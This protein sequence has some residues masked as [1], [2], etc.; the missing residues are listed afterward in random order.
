MNALTLPDRTAD[1]IKAEPAVGLSWVPLVALGLVWAQVVSRLQLEWSINPQYSYGWAVPFLCLY[2]AWRRRETLPAPSRPLWPG[3]GLVFALLAVLAFIPIRLVQEANPDWRLLSWAMSL[4]AVCITFAVVNLAGGL[5]WCRHFAFPILFFLVAVPWPTQFEQMVIQGLMRV[6]ASINVEVL[7]AIGIPAVQLGNLI[8]VG[9]GVVGINE[10]CTGVRSLQATLMI[11]LFLGELYSFSTSKRL[12]LIAAGAALAFVCNLGRTFFL[13][14]VG[15]ER[16]FDAI[17]KW[18][19]PAG[20]TILIICLF[21]L[22]LISIWMQRGVREETAA[23][24]SRATGHKISRF[25]LVGLVGGALAAE[26]TTQIWYGMHEAGE[27]RLPA[28]SVRWPEAET[29]YADVPIAEQAQELLRYNEGGGATWVSDNGTRWSM[30]FFKWLPGRTAGLFLKNH[31]P[32]ICLPASGMRLMG[33]ARHKFFVV[34]GAPL[35]IRSYVFENGSEVLH[36]YYCYWDGSVPDAGT[37]NDENW[38]AAGRLEAVRR[39]KRDV[40]TQMLQLIAS[41]YESEAEA[42]RAVRAQLE[43]IVTRG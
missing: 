12:L 35:P 43:R 37:V 33:E 40:G 6:V 41:G 20:F 4:G 36:V 9:S 15:S 42:E 7:N 21:G 26:A 11:S 1:A 38:T 14:Y 5:R 10:A 24:P 27:S 28:W 29:G 25:L 2:S 34:N 16:G 18:H 3:L 8:E 22:W 17:G 31:R 19:D 30:F 13:V 32:D 39:G 23:A